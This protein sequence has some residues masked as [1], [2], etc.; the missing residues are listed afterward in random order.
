M[1]I[2]NIHF[3]GNCEEAIGFY[4]EAFG[5]EV[6]EINYFRDAPLACGLDD[7]LPPNFV[8]NSEVMIL[9]T[10]ITMTDGGEKPISG[11]NFSFLIYLDTAEEVISV[12]DKLADNGKVIQ[13]LGAQFWVSIYGVVEDRFGVN[14]QVSMRE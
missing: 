6:K 7:S 12:F 1:L 2:P 10:L 8:M 11:E 3:P 14:W 9:G 4:K 5:A 13:P